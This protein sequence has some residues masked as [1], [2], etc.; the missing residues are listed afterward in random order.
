M[1][2]KLLCCEKAPAVPAII[3]SDELIEII[4]K[5]L[6]IKNNIFVADRNYSLLFEEDMKKFLKKNTT[7]AHKYIKEGFD[8]DDFADVL[9]GREREWFALGKYNYGSAFGTV[10]GDIRL[11]EKPDQPRGHAV[12][13]Y[14]NEK[15][16]LWLIEPQNDK[17][18]QLSE[19]S[20]VTLVVC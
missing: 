18:F 4:K 19:S 9:K 6:R 16:E 11:P 8:C 15:K 17:L 13:F 5:S 3:S 1:I 12:N 14:V 10:W 7:D 20:K 2:K